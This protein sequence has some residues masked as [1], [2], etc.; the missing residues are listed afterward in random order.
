MHLKVDFTTVRKDKKVKIFEILFS[1]GMY[2]MS[3]KWW[4]GYSFGEK[5][6]PAERLENKRDD[7]ACRLYQV[8]ITTCNVVIGC[9]ID[10]L[11]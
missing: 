9:L 1:I 8:V 5:V 10:L 11:W 4:S 3:W 7:N 2:K 6:D